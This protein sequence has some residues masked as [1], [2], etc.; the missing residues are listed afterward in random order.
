[1]RHYSSDIYTRRRL[2]K[3]YDF[4]SRAKTEAAVS[5]G[6]WRLLSCQSVG[7]YLP[8]ISKSFQIRNKLP[9]RGIAGCKS[10]L[11][12]NRGFCRV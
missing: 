7:I 9:S 2:A 6:T 4:G 3:V 11:S 8:K 12:P 5:E 10:H 1:M